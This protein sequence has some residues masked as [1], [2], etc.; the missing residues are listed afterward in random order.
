[1]KLRGLTCLIA[2]GIMSLICS[3]AVYAQSRCMVGTE[4]TQFTG[5]L[6]LHPHPPIPGFWG[7]RFAIV[8][9]DAANNP[10]A[11]M[12]GNIQEAIIQWNLHA[13]ET[14]IFFI[15]FNPSVGHTF[16][17]IEFFQLS[18]DLGSTTAGCI[19]FTP[20]YNINY[21]PNFLARFVALPQAQTVAAIMHE[22]GHALGL[23]ENSPGASPTIMTQIT[24]CPQPFAV[25]I[26]VN[27]ARPRL[28]ALTVAL[29]VHTT[30]FAMKGFVPM[31]L[32]SL[33][34]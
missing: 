6:Q 11:L 32:L 9:F 18:A 13:C 23:D 19:A 1:M 2:A 21:G 31:L 20:T 3:S 24:A 26:M 10:L 30:R 22:L 14:G 5:W 25:T 4:L 27:A 29:S 17:D 28:I 16:A 34:T 7:V 12:R 15:P 8:K 33:S